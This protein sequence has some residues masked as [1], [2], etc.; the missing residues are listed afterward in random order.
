MKQVTHSRSYAAKWDSCI[1][2]ENGKI[3]VI[4]NNTSNDYDDDSDDDDDDTFIM[5]NYHKYVLLRITSVHTT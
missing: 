1:C 3:V 2:C 5:R 4:L